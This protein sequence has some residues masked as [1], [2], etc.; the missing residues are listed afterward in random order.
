MGTATEIDDFLRLLFTHAGE[1][2]AVATQPGE[3]ERLPISVLESR[4]Q[5]VLEAGPDEKFLLL[6]PVAFDTT[7]TADQRTAW[8]NDLQA[9]GFFRVFAE[10]AM[11]DLSVVLPEWDAS[12]PLWLVIDRWIAGKIKAVRLREA[13][14]QALKLGDHRLSLTRLDDSE[15]WAFECLPPETFTPSQFS[16]NHPL[17]ACPACEGFGRVIGLDWAKVV[18]NPA[19]SLAQGAIHPFTTPASAE[20]HDAMET[21]ARRSKIPLNKPYAKLT[22]A[23]KALI[24]DGDAQDDYPGVQ[25]F[26]DWLERKRYKM[27]VRVQLA[28]YRSYELCPDCNGARL[29][30]DSLTI[31]VEGRS[32]HDLWQMPIGDLLCWVQTLPTTLPESRYDACKRVCTELETR[33]QYLVGVGLHYLTLGRQSRTLSGG[34]SQRIHLSTALGSALTD[35]LYVLDE[36]TVGLHARDTQQLIR[37]IQAL[38]DQGNTMVVVEHDPDVMAAADHVLDLGPNSGE[39]GGHIL[40][41]GPFEG[42]LTPAVAEIGS[43]T[44]AMLQARQTSPSQAKKASRRRP[45]SSTVD[46]DAIEI[47]GATG[48]N[49]KAV[50]VKIP[51]QQLVCVTGVSGSGKST[52]IMR[53]LYAG[54]QHQQGR[55]LD[56]DAS[57]CV[58]LNGLDAFADVICVDQSPMSRS[59]RSNPA[60]TLK[61]FDLIRKRF[62]ET[63]QAAV[64]GLRAG[65][66]SFNAVGGRCE[67]CEGLGFQTIDMQFMADVVITCPDCKGKRYQHRVLGVEYKGASIHEVLN[68]TVTDAMA[69]FKH[70]AGMC[71]RLDPLKALGLDYLRLGQSTATLSGGEAQRL[72]LATFLK[73]QAKLTDRPNLFLFDEPTTGLHLRDIDR[74]VGVFRTLIAQGHSVVVI[75]HNLDFIAQADHIL[76]LGPEGGEAGGECVFSGTVAEMRSAGIGWTGRFLQAISGVS[77]V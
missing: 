9:Q 62:A 19:L 69:F 16:F 76:E 24:R 42:L 46:A 64:L 14:T 17:G 4:V 31:W 77:D 65:D 21:M 25:G 57:P 41:E 60:T 54:Y 71:K 12:E 38:R 34:E 56:Q 67:S 55:S 1:R 29:K 30:P 53:T 39:Q 8:A 5:A 47:L 49:L 63:R 66:F 32:I 44:A 11:Q 72:K 2:Q 61:A 37:V 7:L 36:P 20:L 15:A 74:L 27:H 51:K 45:A 58:A 52:L 33:L 6:A 28:R 35:T 26:F 18:P 3:P 10:G 59:Q 13:I 23:Q 75:E 43:V 48:H 40:Y 22:D 68:M 73:A 50:D 70:D